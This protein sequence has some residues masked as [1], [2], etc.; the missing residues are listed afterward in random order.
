ML[1]RAHI[2]PKELQLLWNHIESKNMKPDLNSSYHQEKTPLVLI[3]T[4]DNLG[5]AGGNNVGLRYIMKQ[6]DCKYIW[7]LNNDTVVEKNSLLNLVRYSSGKP[8]K[9]LC[10]S[11]LIFYH[12]P[13][14]VQA[15]GGASYNKWTG[16]ATSL[17]KLYKEDKPVDT[18]KIENKLSYIMGASWLIPISFLSEI[19]L[20]EESYFLYYEEIDWCMRGSKN[21]KLCYAND[22]IVYHKEGKSIGSSSDKT[23]TSLFSDFYL[24]RNKL[25]FTRKF[26]PKALIPVYFATFLQ[27]LN[28]LRRKQIDKA[29]LIIQILLGKR[30][31]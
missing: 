29:R 20:M 12:D 13:K 21:Y 24:F 17:G 30:S 15:L 3:Q 28:R 10:G 26:Y 8:F 2:L 14:Y 27:A 4:G 22:S 31:Y 1:R 19:G 18:Q 23:K 7:V 11:K 6:K 5:F 9:N 16:N 25:I